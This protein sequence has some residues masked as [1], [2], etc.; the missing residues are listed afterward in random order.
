MFLL[1]D[2][3]GTK[4]RLAVSCDG[5]SFDEPKIVET[6]Q[7]FNAGMSLFQ[8]I[9]LE[10]SGGKKINAAA[11]GIAGPLDREKT[12]LVNSPNLSGWIDRPLKE[13][14]QK[15]L[16]IPVYLEND[17]A[18]VGLGEAMNGAGRGEEIIAYITVSTGIGG[19]RIVDGKIDRNIFGFEPGHQI[20]DPTGMLCPMC[21]SAGHLE[22]HVS[23]VALEARF[24][25]KAY[26]ITDPQIWEEEAKWLA[27]GLNNTAVYWSPS[28]IV[29]GGSM[30]IKS[31]G[32]SIERVSHHLKKTL[33]IF[34]ERPRL[35]KAEL[36]DIGGLY[37]ALEILKQNFL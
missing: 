26:E 13:T 31:P 22:G 36:G 11:G 27:Y 35:V 12:K 2:I 18:I 21:D 30:I 34:P 5:K 23:G 4:M 16:K 9:T 24:N 15:I 33:T 29:L 3:G 10:L 6:P 8:K 7:D 1:F 32:I 17:A 19:A 28:V 14:L 20:I 37:G 25:K